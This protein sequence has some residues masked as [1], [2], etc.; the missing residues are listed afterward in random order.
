MKRRIEEEEE[1][2]LVHFFD[3]LDISVSINCALFIKALINA[4]FPYSRIVV[5]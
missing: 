5:F 1:E 4:D 2:F 3:F